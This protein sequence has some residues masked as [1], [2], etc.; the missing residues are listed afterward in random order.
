LSGYIT[1]VCGLHGGI[2][3]GNIAFST[4]MTGIIE[5]AFFGCGGITSI[6]FVN[7]VTLGNG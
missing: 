5:D 1:P 2:A 3:C 6:D 7:V 4:D